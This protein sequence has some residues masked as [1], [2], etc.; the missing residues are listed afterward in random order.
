ME[1]LVLEI[2]NQETSAT[3]TMHLSA[4]ALEDQV[5]AGPRIVVDDARGL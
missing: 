1:G 2:Y 4:S 3:S 5:W